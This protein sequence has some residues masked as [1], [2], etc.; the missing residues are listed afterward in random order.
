M[1][2]KTNNNEISLLNSKGGIGDRNRRAT[3]LP[4][5]AEITKILQINVLFLGKVD[6]MVLNVLINRLNANVKP[7]MK[8]TK[9]NTNECK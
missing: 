1:Q 4:Q 6:E 7:R 2:T 5:M 9:T 8:Q 3:N